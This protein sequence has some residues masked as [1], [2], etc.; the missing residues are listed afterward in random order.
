MAFEH[1]AQVGMA[2]ERRRRKSEE[3]TTFAYF[4]ILKQQRSEPTQRSILNSFTGMKMTQSSSLSEF[5]D[6]WKSRGYNLSYQSNQ[7]AEFS[8][9]GMKSHSV[10]RNFG[11]VFDA[12]GCHNLIDSYPWQSGSPE[13]GSMLRMTWN[14]RCIQ[15][16]R[17][18]Q[19]RL[20]EYLD[21]DNG[22][23]VCLR[24]RNVLNESEYNQLKTSM[25][26]E[27]KSHIEFNEELLFEYISPKIESCCKKFVEALQDSHQQHVVNFI[28]Q[29]GEEVFTDVRVLNRGEIDL[30]NTQMFRLVKLIDSH[31][32]EFLYRL[33]SKD[34]ITER[35]K[36]NVEKWP[37]VQKKIDELLKILKRTSYKN[38]C[39]FKRCL[40]DTMEH[41]L[42]VTLKKC[43]AATARRLLH[44]REDKSIIESQII[45][46][47]TDQLD[48]HNV[49]DESLTSEQVSIIT[50][51]L[52][53]LE[54]VHIRLFSESAWKNAV[55]GRIRFNFHS[56]FN[57]FKNLSRLDWK[58]TI[59]NNLI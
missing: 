8:E 33:V 12:M 37:E 5:S 15:G 40:H 51:I 41:R 16:Y 58:K 43:G 19:S 55:R 3:F 31:R 6:I 20:V 59:I 4:D 44:N 27:S 18:V 46:I 17:K 25:R 26:N 48:D 42:G 36:E 28:M 49:I 29:A 56:F 57:L 52:W 35:Q 38:F 7:P 54:T 32:I 23:L 14:D 53:E 10:V 22:L 34:C 1:Y 21:S 39:E 50:A 47:I 30:I 9:I 45:D 2:S 11:S 24:S 13:C